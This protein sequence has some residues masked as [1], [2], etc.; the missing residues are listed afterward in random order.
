MRSQLNPLRFIALAGLLSFSYLAEG[1]LRSGICDGLVLV[2]AGSNAYKKVYASF[3]PNT[4][5]EK[6]KE[7]YT[8]QG[9]FVKQIG[10]KSAVLIDNETGPLGDLSR[11]FGRWQSYRPGSVMI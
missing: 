6:V 2:S 8:K 4:P 10:Y 5:Y 11:R 3:K 9:Y 7:T 1:Q